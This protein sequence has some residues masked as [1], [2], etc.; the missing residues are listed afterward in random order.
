MILGFVPIPAYILVAL[1]LITFVVSVIFV[2]SLSVQ[3]ILHC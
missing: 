2:L 1:Y 3:V